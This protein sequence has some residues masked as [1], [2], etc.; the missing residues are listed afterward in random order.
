L[1][2]QQAGEAARQ[3]AARL[4]LSAQEQTDAARRAQQ[5]FQMQAQQF[6]IEQQRQRAL[7]G[8]EGLSADRAG[9][10]Q[11]LAAAEL[12]SGLG[13]QQQQTDLQRLAALQSVGVDRRNLMQRGLDIGYE[14]FLRQQA[15]G[16]EQLGYLSNLLQGVPINPGSTVSTFGRVPSAGEQLLGGGLGALGL[17]QAFGG[18]GGG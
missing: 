6:N 11:R 14:D 1:Q 17:Y 8:L 13:G 4:G 16:R 10:A 15:Y 9:Q 7:L 2:A 5:Q 18:R 3:E 12:L